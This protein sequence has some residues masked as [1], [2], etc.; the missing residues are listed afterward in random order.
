MIKLNEVDKQKRLAKLRQDSRFKLQN[1]TDAVVPTDKI[2]NLGTVESILEF[3]KR[4]GLPLTEREKIDKKVEDETKDKFQ[5]IN[6]API[7]STKIKSTMTESMKAENSLL[8]LQS[9][10]IFKSA[11]NP[12]NPDDVAKVN[13][14]LVD[15][16]QALRATN[17]TNPY[18]SK[19]PESMEKLKFRVIKIDNFFPIENCDFTMVTVP[20]LDSVFY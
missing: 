18:N 10:E 14:L 12:K 19:F 2:Q 20:L 13:D 9:K 17:E 4:A 5:L 7:D 15:I 8:N 11:L 6:L 1:S 3:K 16:N